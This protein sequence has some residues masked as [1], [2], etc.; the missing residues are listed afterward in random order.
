[1]P[2]ISRTYSLKQG[3]PNDLDPCASEF[4]RTLDVPGLIVFASNS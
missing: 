3:M 2:R 1:M 4:Y